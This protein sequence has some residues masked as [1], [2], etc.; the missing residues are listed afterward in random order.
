MRNLPYGLLFYLSIM[1]LFNLLIFAPPLLLASGNTEL[2]EPLYFGFSF[3]CHQ[4]DTRSL[5]YYESGFPIRYCEGAKERQR[6][7]IIATDDLGLLSDGC[8]SGSDCIVRI[9]YK[10]PVCSRDIGIYFFLLIGGILYP[11][12]KKP[13]TEI[14]PHPKWL[15]LA[16]IPIGL[17]GGTQLLGLRESTNELRLITGAIIGFTAAFYLVPMLNQIINPLIQD[18]LKKK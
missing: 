3:T 10:F 8:L 5:C 15:L 14:W 18:L 7:M 12:I 2:A 6:N 11:F 1:F 9:G 4:L 16:M 17:D 13:T